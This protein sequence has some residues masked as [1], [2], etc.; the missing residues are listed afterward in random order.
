MELTIGLAFIAGIVSFLSPCVLPL[1]PAYIGYMGGRMTN[2]VAV[3]VGMG[4]SGIAVEDRSKF[5]VRFNT[6]LHGLFFVAGF[7]LVFVA[8]GLLSTAFIQQVGGANIS[9][10]TAIIGRVGGIMIVFFGL[11]FMGVLPKIFVWLR[12]H[13]GFLDSVM[14]T[15]LVALVFS[16]LAAWGFTSTLALWDSPLWDTAIAAPVIATALIAL[17]WAWLV[18]GGGFTKPR[19]FWMD[20]LN[21]LEAA[22]YSDTR[23]QMNA[24]SH[25]G[26][27]GSGFM[28][29][30]FAAGWTPCIGPVYGAVLTLAASGGDLGEAGSMLTAY[31]L[32]LGFP[33][34]LTA[35]MLDSA[36]GGLRKIQRHMHTI[37]LVSGGFL[38]FIGVTI[39]SGQ[40]QSWSER[41]AGDFADFSVSLEE[42]VIDLVTSDDQAESA[43]DQ[44]EAAND[45]SEAEV[46]VNR[47]DLEVGLE[48]GNLAPDFQTVTDAGDPAALS[49]L[50]GQ[51]VLLNFWATWCG[52]C[53]V[54]M[55]EF[56]AQ[57]D[58]RAADNFTIL[59]VNNAESV[60]T[61][62]D[63][64]EEFELTFP[65]VMDE[66]ATIQDQ[67]GIFSYPS[68]LMIDENGVIVA[69]H[70]GALTT[71]QIDE[72]I[73]LAVE[74]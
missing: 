5:S 16:G 30:V 1:V 17:L 7:T 58:Q 23:A 47:V 35:L 10:M 70:F 25:S 39:A 26:F 74:S 71:E 31:S 38:I 63:F 45:D 3:T 8:I 46:A 49:D 67:Y 11:H 15:V 60:D 22:L 73:A 72:L 24:S 61:V 12:E 34:L 62:A 13:D 29:V 44:G 21:R 52:P 57:Y 68:T 54:E 27:L 55:P 20:V 43:A 32:G 28:G 66:Q 64:R 65:I 56:Q 37:K 14:T 40:L 18:L 2:N 42:S 9:L 19:E 51:V 4:G 50:R 33:F 59:A 41:L 48:I 6:A 53:R 69:R 36:Q